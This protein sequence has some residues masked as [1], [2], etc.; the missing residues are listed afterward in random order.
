[1]EIPLCVP[2]SAGLATISSLSALSQ[3]SLFALG[4]CL[5]LGVHKCFVG[6]EFGQ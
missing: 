2:V 1:M 6:L 4:G 3:G 5:M